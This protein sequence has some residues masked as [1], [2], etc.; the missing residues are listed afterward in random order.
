MILDIWND[1]LILE[2]VN[3]VYELTPDDTN[4][5]K[6]L[7]NNITNYLEDFQ[8]LNKDCTHDGLRS[9]IYRL[10]GRIPELTI[11]TKHNK[12]YLLDNPIKIKY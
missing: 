10:R 5:L 4:T 6:V 9:E 11:R 3:K 7:A 8:I 2:D 1:R 12:G